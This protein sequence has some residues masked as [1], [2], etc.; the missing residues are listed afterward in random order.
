[1]VAGALPWSVERAT[2]NPTMAG[3]TGLRATN[4]SSY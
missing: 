1:M 4:I 2:W 3:L